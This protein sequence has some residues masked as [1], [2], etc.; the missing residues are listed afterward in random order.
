MNN[1][2]D[3]N[4]MFWNV[5]D[6]HVFTVDCNANCASCV[7]DFPLKCTSCIV[8]LYLDINNLCVFPCLLSKYAIT[9]DPSSG[10]ICVVSCP[11]GYYPIISPNKI[12]LKCSVGC[13]KCTSATDCILFQSD[14]NK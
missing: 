12:C 2:R 10:G 6:L 11:Q 3:S 14:L 5:F 13:L 7:I 9:L 1:Q 8:G 4:V